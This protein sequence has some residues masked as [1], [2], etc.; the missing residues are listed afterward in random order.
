MM[1]FE[2]DK[3]ERYVV[4]LAKVLF[5]LGV[6]LLPIIILPRIPAYE[7]SFDL[8]E[9]IEKCLFIYYVSV[10]IGGGLLSI[11]LYPLGFFIPSCVY[12]AR[13]FQPTVQSKRHLGFVAFVLLFFAGIIFMMFN[14]P[15]NIV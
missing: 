6:L 4:R 11:I 1:N 10:G 5:V 2:T 9:F 15:F 12:L 3:L 13:Y 7:T 14:T 8:P